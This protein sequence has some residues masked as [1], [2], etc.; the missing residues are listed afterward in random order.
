MKKEALQAA[1]EHLG[2]QRSLARELTKRGIPVE[3]AHVWNWLHRNKEV[4][5][6]VCPHLECITEGVVTREQLRPDVFA[7][8]CSTE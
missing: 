5:A 4:P 8:K 1:I 7:V 6:H 2:G 3:Q